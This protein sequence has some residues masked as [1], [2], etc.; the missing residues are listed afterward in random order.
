[1]S[2]SSLLFGHVL[3]PMAW[4]TW[5]C[6]LCGPSP[7]LLFFSVLQN[8]WSLSPVTP[9]THLTLP[10]ILGLVKLKGYYIGV[11]PMSMS[12][13]SASQE[14]R[15]FLYWTTPGCL[16]IASF[17]SIAG[18]RQTALCGQGAGLA[19]QPGPGAAQ[20]LACSILAARNVQ[21]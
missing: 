3:L 19:R 18:A 20:L 15:N 6:L 12:T 8:V 7:S 9:Y 5:V 11:F 4:P 17:R 14:S 16:V 21:P 2:A 13:L 1:M 10:L